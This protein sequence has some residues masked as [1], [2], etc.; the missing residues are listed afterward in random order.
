MDDDVFISKLNEITREYRLKLPILEG[1]R[2]PKGSELEVWAR[3]FELCLKK[4]ISLG[5]QRW[6]RV[7][8]ET[9]GS[10]AVFSLEGTRAEAAD[11][12]FRVGL[13]LLLSLFGEGRSGQ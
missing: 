6:K 1:G 10:R 3:F 9:S 2:E 5:D 12:D 8:M 13:K 7:K 4:G 11:S